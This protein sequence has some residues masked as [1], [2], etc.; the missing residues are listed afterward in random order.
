[1]S[2]PTDLDLKA[3]AAVLGMRVSA[4]AWHQTAGTLGAILREHGLGEDVVARFAPPPAPR[5]ISAQRKTKAP[6]RKQKTAPIPESDLAL[7][8]LVPPAHRKD[9]PA[10]SFVWA[11]FAVTGTA[12]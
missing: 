11:S 8:P 3:L 10:P 12:H 2:G 6:A 7:E 9:R 4:V 1:M 5:P